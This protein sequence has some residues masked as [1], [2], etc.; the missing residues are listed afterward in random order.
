MGLPRNE[1]ALLLPISFVLQSHQGIGGHRSDAFDQQKEI[2][3][4]LDQ[5]ADVHAH[6]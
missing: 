6:R 5:G 2:Q 3:A 4:P 1:S